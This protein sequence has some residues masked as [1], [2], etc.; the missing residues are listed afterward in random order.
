MYKFSQ[1]LFLTSMESEWLGHTTV[2]SPVLPSSYLIGTVK[3]RH[4][5]ISKS[6]RI[7]D[8]KSTP[9]LTIDLG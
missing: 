3:K 9:K 4:K 8:L 5:M 7:I 6:I 1:V 2:G